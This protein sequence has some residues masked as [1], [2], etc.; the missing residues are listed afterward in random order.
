MEG[1]IFLNNSQSSHSSEFTIYNSISVV[2]CRYGAKLIIDGEMSGGN[3][4][5]V[6]KVV[7]TLLL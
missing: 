7:L 3:L 2:I 1:T 5:I 6:R 4:L